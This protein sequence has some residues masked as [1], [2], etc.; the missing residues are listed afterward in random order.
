[1][2]SSLS[3]QIGQLLLQPHCPLCGPTWAA[4]KE[5]AAS[6]C[7]HCRERL[8]LPSQPLK[9][10]A[11]VPWMAAGHYAGQLRTLILQLRSSGHEHQIRSLSNSLQNALPAQAILIPIPSW[12]QANRA[13]PLPERIAKVLNRP[14]ASFLERS[15][16]V[17][18]QHR[19]HRR[20]RWQNQWDSFR[21]NETAAEGFAID[22]RQ[23]QAWLVDDIITTGATVMAAITTLARAGIAV[24]GTACLGRTPMKHPL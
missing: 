15:R 3:F 13:N 16:A 2:W 21:Y 18:G 19:L 20:Q 24:S 7:S 9:G 12:K 1:M 17:I 6:A 10:D 8:V 23:H 11:P 4:A 22:W 5:E 14:R